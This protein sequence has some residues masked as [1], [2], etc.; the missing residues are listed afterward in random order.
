M[1]THLIAAVIAASAA[2]GVTA[3]HYKLKIAKRDNTDLQSQVAGTATAIANISANQTVMA[4]AFADFTKTTQEN[5]AHADQVQIALRGISADIAGVRR[6]S[7]DM[8]RRIAAATPSALAEYATTCSAVFAAMVAGGGELAS[9]GAGIAEKAAGH[10]AD[11][12]RAVT[13]WPVK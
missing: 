2:W 4:N 8:P 10:N 12:I 1:K 5:K 9:A 3:Q 6:D 13:S 7:A 11:A